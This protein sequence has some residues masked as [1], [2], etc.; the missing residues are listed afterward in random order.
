MHAYRATSYP[1]ALSSS[2]LFGVVL[3][4]VPTPGGTQR[5]PCLRREAA[6]ACLFALIMLFGEEEP[7]IT[8]GDEGVGE[9]TH[10]LKSL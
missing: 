10:L 7:W 4:S 3:S 6:H 9:E 8:V 1:S 5:R 2:Y